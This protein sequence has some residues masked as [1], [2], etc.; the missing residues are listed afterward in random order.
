M[1]AR[2]GEMAAPMD[3]GF[4]GCIG[5]Q[6]ENVGREYAARLSLSWGLKYIKDEDAAPQ[7]KK[8]NK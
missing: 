4:V 2:C 8:K 1:L 5:G 7:L 6:V 3:D